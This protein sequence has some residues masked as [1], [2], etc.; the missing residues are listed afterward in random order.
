LPEDRPELPEVVPVEWLNTTCA[1]YRKAA[2]PEPPFPAHFVGYS[3]M[4]DVAL[5]LNVGK[6]WKLANARTARIFH[7]SQ[8]ARYKD[9]QAAMARM[10]LINRHFIM[11]RILAR[12]R[13]CDYLKL[14]LL[15]L[16]GVAT[17]LTSAK[18][19]RALPS[20][21]V[22]KAGAVRSIVRGP[23]ENPSGTPLTENRKTVRV[24][25]EH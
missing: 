23:R 3:F 4:E 6:K 7:D 20:V 10:E 8:P 17:S 11:S 1:L 19:W 15:E 14:A 16:F 18:G 5:S 22:G 13:A 2:L 24:E 9:N 21:L 12:T 25:L